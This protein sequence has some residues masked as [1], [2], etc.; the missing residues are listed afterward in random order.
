M[1]WKISFGLKKADVLEHPGFILHIW[2]RRQ[3]RTSKNHQGDN[4]W[5]AEQ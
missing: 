2:V 5:Q 3:K 4:R 1:V